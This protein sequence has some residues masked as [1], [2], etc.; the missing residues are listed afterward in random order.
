MNEYFE[1]YE[2]PKKYKGFSIEP[3][4][5][6]D[7]YDVFGLKKLYVGSFVSESFKKIGRY[8]ISFL[9]VPVFLSYFV[10]NTMVAFY[11]FL[12]G[13]SGYI[14]YFCFYMSLLLVLF[15]FF[16]GVCGFADK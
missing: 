7:V 14:V 15:G 3:N 9:L 11:L 12:N 16:F 1:W 4:G 2:D 10:L 6:K 13:V 5:E 8:H